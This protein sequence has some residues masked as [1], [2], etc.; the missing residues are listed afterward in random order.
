M[1]CPVCPLKLTPEVYQWF[2]KACASC[3]RHIK[4]MMAGFNGVPVEHRKIKDTW[5]N[6]EA[7]EDWKSRLIP[8]DTVRAVLDKKGEYVDQRCDIRDM[9]RVCGL[10]KFLDLEQQVFTAWIVEGE[11]NERMQEV[12]GLTFGQLSHVKTVIK[13]RLQK[14]MAYYHTIKKLEEENKVR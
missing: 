4:Q 8:S 6:S 14:Q 10:P 9:K 2:D 3:Q 7:Y 13:I 11:N 5:D 12:L 1:S